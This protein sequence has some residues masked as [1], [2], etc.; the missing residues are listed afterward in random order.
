V[1]GN[2]NTTYAGAIARSRFF[3][4]ISDAVTDMPDSLGDFSGEYSIG[5]FTIEGI[6]LA[7]R[8]SYL[9]AITGL[10][11]DLVQDSCIAAWDLGT[12]KLK[13][14]RTDNSDPYPSDGIDPVFA[15]FGVTFQGAIPKIT[16][17]QDGLTFK[18]PTNWPPNTNDFQVLQV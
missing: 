5:T 2:I 8:N 4:G 9:N 1:T 3:A 15:S 12:V 13:Q 14:I 17:R 18:W 6:A 16:W 11:D 10:T 7:A